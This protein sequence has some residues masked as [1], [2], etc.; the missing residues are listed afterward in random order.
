VSRLSLEARVGL[1][2]LVAGVLLSVFLFLLSGVRVGG[3]WDVYVDFG[4]PGAVQGGAPVRIGGIK[5]GRVEDVRYLGGG[6]DPRTG[7]RALVRMRL[8]IDDDVKPTLHDDALFYVTAQ[9]VLGEQFIA[10]DPGTGERPL[11]REGAIV[12]GV[13]PPRLDLAL[14]LGYELLQAVVDGIRTHREELGDLIS[15]LIEL[16]RGLATLFH[17]N[18]A[19]IEHILANLETATE[20]AS[21]LATGVRTQYIDSAQV[22]RIVTNLDRTLAAVSRDVEP[23]MRDVRTTTQHA[24]QVL[25]TIG[26]DEQAHLRSAIARADALTEEAQ[27]TLDDAHAIVAHVRRGEGT[28]GAFLMDEEVY[29]DVAE[30][31]RDLK[32][33]PWKLFWRD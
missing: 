5:V 17:G 1:L 6:L 28:V 32:H 3:G 7:R 31:V 13:D 30:L 21:Q 4:N 8:R 15:G 10:I 9:G 29:D 19:R 16:V 14:S 18:Q 11:L 33:S 2:V 27:G 23:L 20:E 12:H 22:H 25:G 24:D 26:P